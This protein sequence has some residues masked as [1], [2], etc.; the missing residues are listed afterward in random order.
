MPVLVCISTFSVSPNNKGVN[1]PALAD[2]I[3]DRLT[4]DD[5]HI[6]LKGE[7]VWTQK[8]P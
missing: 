4:A 6:E 8:S 3:L 7:L 1:D 2:A 5:H